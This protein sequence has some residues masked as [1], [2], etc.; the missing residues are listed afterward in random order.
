MASNYVRAAK[1]RLLFTHYRKHAANYAAGALTIFMIVGVMTASWAI[2]SK[3][4]DL[5]LENA[6]NG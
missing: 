4:I 3:L 1:L 5:V 2:W 6:C